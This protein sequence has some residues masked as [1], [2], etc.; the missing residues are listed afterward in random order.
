MSEAPEFVPDSF[1]KEIFSYYGLTSSAFIL[2]SGVIVS[3]LGL[4]G[5]I[6]PAIWL[7]AACLA[8]ILGYSL[9]H[10]ISNRFPLVLTVAVLA[11]ALVAYVSIRERLYPSLIPAEAYSD[12]FASIIVSAFPLLIISFSFAVSIISYKKH[13]SIIPQSLL[14]SI[15]AQLHEQV[16]KNPLYYESFVCRIILEYDDKIGQVR[17]DT[18]ITMKVKNRENEPVAFR[19]RYPRITPRFRLHE[20][21]VDQVAK[22]I[23]NPRYHSGDAVHLE[24]KIAGKG[25]AVV[26]ARMTEIFPNNGS[27]LYTAYS[28][29][30]ANF[31][32]SLLNESTSTI[33]AWIEVLNDHA[34]DIRVENNYL[35]WVSDKAIL[36]YQGTRIVWRQV[37]GN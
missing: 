3:G 8:L 22:D 7:F 5:V 12:A 32:I 30:A 24:E 13:D 33:D 19:H 36:P 31:E 18:S 21:R 29:P 1:L 35:V 2:F 27:E 11:S 26:D 23:G 14:P 17:L 20:V 16:I 10:Y 15:Q 28:Y 25:S 9:R 37:S 6:N 4:Q 34:H